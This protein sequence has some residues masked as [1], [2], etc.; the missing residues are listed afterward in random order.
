V[1]GIRLPFSI[2]RSDGDS[3]NDVKIT[4]LEAKVDAPLPAGAFA[5]PRPIGPEPGASR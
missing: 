4:L 5:K 1:S 2:R 3:A